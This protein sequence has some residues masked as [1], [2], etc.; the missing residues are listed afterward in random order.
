MA[1]VSPTQFLRFDDWRG[2]F[3]AN[4]AGEAWQTVYGRIEGLREDGLIY[5][6]LIPGD[7]VKK[8]LDDH[9]WDLTVGSGMPGTSQSGHGKDAKILYDRWG[10]LDGIEPLVFCRSFHTGP[11]SF[12]ELSEEFR[13][14]HNLYQGKKKEEFVKD[15]EAGNPE[16]VARILPSRVEI[17]TKEIRQYLSI[18][19][20]QLSI[21]LDINRYSEVP[22][23]QFGDK[24]HE[25][26]VRA[27]DHSFQWGVRVCTF[28]D[29]YST[30][31]YLCGKKLLGPLPKEESGFWPYSDP[32]EEKYPTYIIGRDEAGH[33]IESSCAY[34]A[35]KNNFG[36]NPEAPHYLTPVHFRAEVLGKYYSHPD[37]YSVEDGY[38]RAGSKWGLRMDNDHGDR[39]VVFLGDLGRDLPEPE[40]L[41]WRSFN[42]PPD[43]P[44]LSKTAFTRNIRGWFADPDR[45]DLAFKNLFRY[46]SEKWRKKHGWELFLPLGKDDMHH[47]TALHIPIHNDQAE[48]D[49]QVQSLTKLII[50]SLNESELVKGLSLPAETM[51]ISKLDAF[52]TE[53]KVKNA[54]D[55]I[56]FL[57]GLQ[58]LR[59]T[60]VAHR[61]GGKYAKVAKIFDLENRELKEVAADLF[62]SALRMLRELGTAF[63]PEE[64]WDPE[65]R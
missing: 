15:D 2:F 61:K 48:F 14:F 7:N 22:L 53:N 5:S 8:A 24:E 33:D 35:L 26:I 56:R 41:Y 60:G 21:Q 13:H 47:F 38:L 52:L 10:F 44:P 3:A 46:F 16:I 39:V 4:L 12:R 32:A 65:K 45:P 1:A 43:G 17:R 57:R 36:A 30:H 27:S 58:N 42:I 37:R 23:E 20:M 51:G 6:A 49:G 11:E 18:K 55:I 63:L 9:C 28:R 40:R 25:E 31:A 54:P 50:D 62:A 34:A 29:D 19:E 59:S 64:E